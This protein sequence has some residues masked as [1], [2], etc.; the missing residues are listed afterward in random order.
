MCTARFHT[1][2]NLEKK[3]IGEI[4]GIGEIGKLKMLDKRRKSGT[5]NKIRKPAKMER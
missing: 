1:H 5:K 2:Q 3:K 4:E